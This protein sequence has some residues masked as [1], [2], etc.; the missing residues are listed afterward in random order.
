MDVPTERPPGDPAHVAACTALVQ[1]MH[2]VAVGLWPLLSWTGFLAITGV[3]AEP[4]LAQQVAVL[5]VAVGLT[6]ALAGFRRH[7]DGE[8]GVLAAGTAAG[9]ACVDLVHVIAGDLGPIYLVDALAEALFTFSWFWFLQ[10]NR[11]HSHVGHPAAP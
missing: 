6:L 1:G 5:A 10:S 2:Y 8:M 11:R 3:R 9:L 7:L 4:W